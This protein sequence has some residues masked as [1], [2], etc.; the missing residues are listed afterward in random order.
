L[1]ADVPPVRAGETQVRQVVGNLLLNALDATP[2]GGTVTLATRHRPE[3]RTVRFTV[4][5]TGPGVRV[6]EGED[7]FDP[8]VT[9]K[10]DGVGLGLYVCRRN[11]EACGGHIDYD[12]GQEGT[13]FWFDLPAAV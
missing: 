8:F 6:P 11:V 12:S 9:T 7:L 1:G 4:A 5:D 2:P 10:T 3:E 13:R